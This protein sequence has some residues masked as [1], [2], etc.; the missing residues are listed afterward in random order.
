MKLPSRWWVLTVETPPEREYEVVEELV[1][2]GS[3]SVRELDG[4]VEAYLP[5]PGRPAREAVVDVE[6]RIAHA[7][8]LDDVR[9]SWRFEEA[10][11]WSR[12]WREGLRARRVGERIWVTPSWDR[13]SAS[14]DDIVIVVDPAMA[15][16]TGEHGTTRGC[17]RLLEPIVRAGMRVLDVGTGTGVL[18]VAAAKLGAAR[19]HG[20]D[21]DP[22]AIENA[23]GTVAGN[24]V[25]ERVTL[26]TREVDDAYLRATPAAWDLIVANVLSGVLKP[27]LPAFAVALAPGARLILSGILQT[28]ADDVVAAARAAGFELGREDR[29]DEWWSG[30]FRQTAADVGERA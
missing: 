26:E 10:Q 19:V 22:E 23:V 30:S 16:G 25:A 5:D 2:M 17:I 18:A 6:R 14:D 7:A 13:E 1:R 4:E 8:G 9:I 12:L 27:L 3:P 15:F 28:E 11:D 21:F 24:G 29:E 20:V